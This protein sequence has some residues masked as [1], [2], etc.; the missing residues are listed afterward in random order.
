M[1]YELT[2]EQRMLQDMVRRLAK[3]RVEPGATRR[4]AEGEFDWAMVDLMRENG[5]YG[6][7]FPE[8]YGGSG[9]GMLALAIAVEELSK[10]DAACGL[11][12][13]DHELGSLPIMLAGNEEQ[14][15]RFLPKLAIGE[16]LAAFALTEPA[17]GSDVARLRCKAIK[18]GDSY[19]L[20]GTKNFITNGGV[21]DIITV[22]AITDPE[23]K[24][25]KNAAVFVVEK[26]TPG[27]SVGKKEDKL[28][29]RWSDTVELIFEDCRVPAENLL[30]QENEGFHVMMKTLDFSRPGV[31]A[32]ALG[33]AA[34]A[35]EYATG[36]AKERES[37][38]KP[39]IRHQ[40]IGFKL[41]EMAM[42]TEAARQLLYKTCALYQEL[43]K[44]MSRLTPELIRMS[45]MSKCF[46]GDVAMWVTIEAVQVLGGYGYVKEFPVERMMRDA[47][48]TQIYEGTNEIMRLVISNTL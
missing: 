42:R 17:A 7:D 30:G 44:D 6:I 31:A 1:Q 29:I 3:E 24:A 37:F 16:H 39:I 40:G 4:D 27:F 5:L 21:A 22:Y 45:S 41:A 43:S 19:I 12:V 33:I 11:L 23:G 32:Q 28:G 25:H 20:N 18:D 34:G 2:E 15:Q 13:A 38:G 26:D 35:L 47:K 14:R 48:I 46:C 36:Y 8:A 9:A 10:V